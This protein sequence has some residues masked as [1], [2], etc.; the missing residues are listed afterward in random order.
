MSERIDLCLATLADFQ[1]YQESNQIELSPTEEPSVVDSV[2]E[3]LVA[4]FPEEKE[5]VAVIPKEEAKDFLRRI[6]GS[7]ECF[8]S[9]MSIWARRQGTK[10]LHDIRDQL[11]REKTSLSGKIIIE[12]GL[13]TGGALEIRLVSYSESLAPYVSLIQERFANRAREVLS[14]FFPVP[15]KPVSYRAIFIL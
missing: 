10:F 4:V 1:K 11:A 13:A 14:S 7:S 5:S 3:R 9:R 6:Q 2:E 15:E 12:I 8:S